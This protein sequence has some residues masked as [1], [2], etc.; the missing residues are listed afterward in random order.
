MNFVEHK[1]FTRGNNALVVLSDGTTIVKFG[2]PTDNVKFNDAVSTYD[3]YA[4][5][6]FT[7]QSDGIAVEFVFSEKHTRKK[8]KSLVHVPQN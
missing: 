1:M 3:C 5:V 2:F 4:A 6:I 7:F 8:N